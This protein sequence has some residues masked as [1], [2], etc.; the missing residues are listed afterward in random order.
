M[1]LTSFTD[2]SLRVL[3]YLGLHEAK[4]VTIRQVSDAFGISE[5]HLMKVIYK[6]STL[7]YVESVRG[8]GGGIRLAGTPEETRL[9]HLVRQVEPDF[10]IV[11]CFDGQHRQECV[12]D[13]SC[14]LRAV[15]GKALDAFLA[16]LD[17]HTLADLLRN[18]NKL[19]SLLRIGATGKARL[20]TAASS[21]GKGKHDGG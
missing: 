9:G 18:P 6:L 5:N 13:S 4:L 10:T 12:I 17:R 14:H 21:S 3:I 15:L 11:E 1:R 8:R 7:G 20:A 2:Y 19:R 16:E